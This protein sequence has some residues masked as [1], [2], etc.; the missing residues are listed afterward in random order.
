MKFANLA[1]GPEKAKKRLAEVFILLEHGL[2]GA[3]EKDVFPT[4]ILT[5]TAGAF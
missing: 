4:I 3:F 1:S 5:G 2:P